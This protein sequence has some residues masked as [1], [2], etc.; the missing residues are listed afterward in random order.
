MNIEDLLN[1]GRV[2]LMNHR[3]DDWC[4]TLK[5]RNGDD[6]NCDVEVQ[7]VDVT[8]MTDEEIRQAMVG[9]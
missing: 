2:T 9:G 3:H 8:D 4:K 1:P 7:F 6:C 5:T